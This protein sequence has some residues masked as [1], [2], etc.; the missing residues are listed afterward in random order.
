[1]VFN[2]LRSQGQEKSRF[3]PAS[4][5]KKCRGFGLKTRKK[6]LKCDN[7]LEVGDWYHLFLN[8]G[9]SWCNA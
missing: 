5:L 7:V 4:A 3:Q 6:A 1:M 8:L 2:P 9:V